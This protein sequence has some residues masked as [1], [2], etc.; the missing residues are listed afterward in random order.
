MSIKKKDFVGGL[1]ISAIVLGFSSTAGAQSPVDVPAR[2]GLPACQAALNQCETDLETAQKFP[3]TGQQT[4]YQAGDD[5]EFQAG[6]P[7]SYTEE[8]TD[9]EC[10]IIDNN[11]NLMWEK[12]PDGN[13]EDRYTWDEAFAYIDE[14]NTVNFA[15][16]DDWRIPN[17]KELQSI[18][19][20]GR[21]EPAID[22]IFGLTEAGTYWSSTS[23]AGFSI[24]AWDVNFFAGGFVGIDEKDSNN[25]G[26]RAVRGGLNNN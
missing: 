24:D 20:Y 16:Y 13:V 3:A 26:V 2:G 6:A 18:V 8:C 7:L 5:G 11:T 9:G 21:S 15:G 10:V 1:S 4:S 19:D 22:P 12:K 23:D 14:L 25:I 17:A